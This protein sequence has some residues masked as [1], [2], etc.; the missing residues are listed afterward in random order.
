LQS[1][2]PVRH[3]TSIAAFMHRL[4]KVKFFAISLSPFE[5]D[6]ET[7]KRLVFK[8]DREMWNCLFKLPIPAVV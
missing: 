7:H 3:H 4:H 1:V 6:F 8:R 2:D 5:S